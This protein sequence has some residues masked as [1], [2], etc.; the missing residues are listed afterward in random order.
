MS[1]YINNE[2]I[3]NKWGFGMAPLKQNTADKNK[4]AVSTVYK[5]LKN[6]DFD[7]ENIV[8]EDISIFKGLINRCIKQDQWDWFTV[9]A[10][11]YYPDVKYLKRIL[12]KITELRKFIK[13]NDSDKL[14][15][16]IRYLN[17]NNVKELCLEYLNYELKDNHQKVQYIYILS[18]RQDKETLKIGETTRNVE[19]RV[20]EINSATGVLRPYSVRAVFKVKDSKL[21]EKLIFEKLKDYRIR[22]DREFFNINYKKA[23]KIIEEVLEENNL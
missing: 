14:D 13:E 12:N 4:K 16:T 18:I 3:H 2:K 15:K 5:I 8:L 6:K 19:T 21:A 23:K 10:M 20:K 11:F 1:E 9:Y 17:E 22:K 7:N